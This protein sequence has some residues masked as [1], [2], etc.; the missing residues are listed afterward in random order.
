MRIIDLVDDMESCNNRNCRFLASSD[1]SMQIGTAV[2]YFCSDCIKLLG[3]NKKNI[4]N[5]RASM[6]KWQNETE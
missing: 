4:D 6:E 5:S 3:K 1:C 2:Y